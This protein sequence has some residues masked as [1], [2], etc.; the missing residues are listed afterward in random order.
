MDVGLR[1]SEK[2]VSPRSAD[3]NRDRIQSNLRLI[4]EEAKADDLFR[5]FT[6]VDAAAKQKKVRSDL[7]RAI[8]PRGSDVGVPEQGAA[9]RRPPLA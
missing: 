6:K 7:P 8:C 1:R 9:G 5:L 3:F 4:M 2:S